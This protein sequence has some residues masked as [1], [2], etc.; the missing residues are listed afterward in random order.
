MTL[1]PRLSVVVPTFDNLD[2]LK[3][4][5]D[6]WQQ[7]ADGLPVELV[8][9]EDGCHDETPAYLDAMAGSRWGRRHLR[10]FHEEDAHE[11][12]CTNRGFAE[13]RAPLLMPWQDDMFVR[14]RWFVT[15]LI[16]T[17]DAYADL[18]LLSLSRGLNLFPADGEIDSWEAL[19]DWSRL[20]STIGTGLGNWFRLQEVDSV[21]RPWV[22]RRTCLDRA[23]ALDEAFVPTEWDEADLCHRIR[24]AGWKVATHGYERLGGYLHLGSSTLGELSD[25]YTTRVL[26]NGLLFHERWDA[27]IAETHA[28][29]RVRWRRRASLAGYTQTLAQMVRRAMS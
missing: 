9:I 23:G 4:C 27:M 21:M 11:L 12:R 19:V 20:R 16:D 8:V 13:G 26:R 2:V 3:R 14:A 22:V 10:W 24:Q 28:R 17:F 18:G 6:S 29:H 7:Y 15:E 25:A 5:L 1:Q